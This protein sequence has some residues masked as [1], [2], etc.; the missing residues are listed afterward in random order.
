MPEKRIFYLVPNFGA[1]FSPASFIRNTLRF[2]FRANRSMLSKNMPPT[3]GIKVIYQHC[4]LLGNIGFYAKPLLLGDLKINW[5]KTSVIPLEL[6]DIGYDLS[7]DDIV[8]CPE[9]IP[10]EGL[11]FNGARKIMFVLSWIFAAPEGGMIREEDVKKTYYE[12]GYDRIISTGQYVTDFLYKNKKEE[13]TTIPTG[14]DHSRFI[15]N[16]AIKKENRILYLPRKNYHDAKGIIKIVKKE[17][18]FAKF[19]K[20]DNLTEEEI[21]REYQRADIF[22]AT[23]YPEGLGLPPLEAMACG[24]AVTGFTGGGAN[25]FMLEGKTALVANDGDINTAAEKLI[26]L[27]RNRKLKETIRVNG[28]RKSKEYTFERMKQALKSFYESYNNS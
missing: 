13:A 22:L 6:K 26:E 17:L 27:L 19:I 3:G 9:F 28:L 21:I 2:N 1:S 7:S 12:L 25:E 24:C 4:E 11:K 20:A 5:F 18:P 14:I 16:P 23:G 8:V 10:Y 15:Y